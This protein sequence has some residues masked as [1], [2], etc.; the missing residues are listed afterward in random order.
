MKKIM[1]QLLLSCQ[2]A[3]ELTEKKALFSI[4]L[5][6][7]IQLFFHLFICKSCSAY[8]HHSV[9]LDEFLQRSQKKNKTLLSEDFKN[10]LSNVLKNKS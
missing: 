1:I 6:E 8:K 9:K 2:K 5:T 4:M 7:R 3:S 10:N